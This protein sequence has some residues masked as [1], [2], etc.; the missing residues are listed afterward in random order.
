MIRPRSEEKMKVSRLARR[1]INWTPTK[2][3]RCSQRGI[4]S[5]TRRAD[6]ESP[7]RTSFNQCA[8]QNL[9]APFEPRCEIDHSAIG[10]FITV[11]RRATSCQVQSDV[12]S[13]HL[14][15]FTQLEYSRAR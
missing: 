3:A 14:P 1:R 15:L 13:D 9:Y 7:L 10:H 2:A 6:A 4:G 11:R 8:D 5:G 12:G